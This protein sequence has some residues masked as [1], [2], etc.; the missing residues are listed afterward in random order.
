MSV[1]ANQTN[2][3]LSQILK[4]KNDYLAF[5]IDETSHYVYL[6]WKSNAKNQDDL[7]TLMAKHSTKKKRK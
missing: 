5:C 3:P 7:K 6:K 2:R 4:I 1:L